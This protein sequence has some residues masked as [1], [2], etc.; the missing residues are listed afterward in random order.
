VRSFVMAC[1]RLIPADCL[2]G[3]HSAAEPGTLN[4]RLLTA[5]RQASRR[6]R[7]AP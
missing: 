2:S 5:Y 7:P 4:L 6:L 1:R 3:H